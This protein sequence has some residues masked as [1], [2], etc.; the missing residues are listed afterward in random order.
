MDGNL[1]SHIKGRAVNPGALGSGDKKKVRA[2]TGKAVA[3]W[4]KVFN[5]NTANSALPDNKSP[6][7]INPSRH[8]RTNILNSHTKLKWS[9]LKIKKKKAISRGL[10]IT[11]NNIYQSTLVN[12]L[13]IRNHFKNKD[14]DVN[15][16]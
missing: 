5:E 16:C 6:N 13:I 3:D 10:K 12:N 9:I 14:V 7:K 15:C 11:F 2:Y 8:K 4:R 1:S